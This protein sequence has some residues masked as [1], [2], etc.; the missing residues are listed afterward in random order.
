[1]SISTKTGD[2]GETGLIGG[3]RVTKDHPLLECLG[4]IDE[5][6]AFLGDARAA[7]QSA[8]P[9]ASELCDAKLHA[10]TMGKIIIGIQEELFTVSGILAGSGA[11]APGEERLSALIGE[12]EAGQPKFTAFRVPGAG[13]VSAKLHIARTVCRRA[14]RRLVGLDRLGELPEGILPWFNRLS[15]LLFLLAG[16]EEKR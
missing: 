12:L 4:T 5:L 8:S 1:M 13:P 7:W 14:E 2:G 3:R 16:Q 6:N 11:A 10:I 9:P 15:D